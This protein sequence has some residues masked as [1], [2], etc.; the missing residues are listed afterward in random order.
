[1]AKVFDFVKMAVR[2]EGPSTR[3]QPRLDGDQ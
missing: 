1:M 3:P 2:T